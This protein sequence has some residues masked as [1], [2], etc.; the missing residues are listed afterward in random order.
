MK[1]RILSILIVILLLGLVAC[2]SKSNDPSTPAGGTAGFLDALKSK[3]PEA[4]AKYYAG[5]AESFQYDESKMESTDF[6]IF[7]PEVMMEFYARMFDCDYEIGEETVDEDHATIPVDITTYDL[8]GIGQKAMQEAFSLAMSDTK[9]ESEEEAVA[10]IS[11]I[12]K[13]G[14]ENAKK[15]HEETILLKLTKGED[16]NWKVDPLEDNEEV[17]GVLSGGMLKAHGEE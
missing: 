13:E 4:I 15:D 11:N 12:C 5:D 9:I 17:V 16:G 7:S 8:Q 6:G 2:G 10:Y 1:N 3:D 14:L